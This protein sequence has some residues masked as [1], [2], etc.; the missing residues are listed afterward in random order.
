MRYVHVFPRRAFASGL[1]AAVAMILTTTGSVAAV[2]CGEVL[3]GVE[4]LDEDL[5]C[6]TDPALTL[7]GGKLD[8]RGHTVICDGTIEGSCWMATVLRS[9]MAPLPGA[10]SPYWW[11]APATI[12]SPT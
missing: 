2:E 12:W 1:C 4:R 11:K 9:S 3:T 10:S 8:L 5:I 6:T 7:N